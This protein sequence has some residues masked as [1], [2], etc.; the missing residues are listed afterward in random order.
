MMS[1]KWTKKPTCENCKKAGHKAKTCWFVY[2]P[3]VVNDFNTPIYSKR[4]SK[5]HFKFGRDQLAVKDFID[6]RF[7]KMAQDEA[8]AREELAPTLI[9]RKMT[10]EEKKKYLPSN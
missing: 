9:V 10:D 6:P 8:K 2:K 3:T 7:L 5:P 4:S 1:S